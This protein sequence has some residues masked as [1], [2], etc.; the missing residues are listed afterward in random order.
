MKTELEVLRDE[1]N[2][3]KEELIDIKYDSRR[4]TVLEEF[5]LKLSERLDKIEK[6]LVDDLSYYALKKELDERCDVS[7][8]KQP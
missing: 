1:L 5:T 3:L 8:A 4:I 2:T 7:A 6:A